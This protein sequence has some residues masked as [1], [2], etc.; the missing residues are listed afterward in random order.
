MTFRM[1]SGMTLDYPDGWNYKCDCKSVHPTIQPIITPDIRGL[2]CLK[3]GQSGRWACSVNLL[4][5]CL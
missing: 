4:M 2:T 3:R 5:D 1:E